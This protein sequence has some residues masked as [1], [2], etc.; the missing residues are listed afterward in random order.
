[1]ARYEGAYIPK[2]AAEEP[3]PKVVLDEANHSLCTKPFAAYKACEE[4]ITEKG[5]GECAPWYSDYL[6]CIDKYTAKSLF[7]KLV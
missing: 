1:M 4:R 5:R 7:K 6:E 2:E 3:D